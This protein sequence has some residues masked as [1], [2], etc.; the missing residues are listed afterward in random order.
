MKCKYCNSDLLEEN[1]VCPN[2]KKNNAE[3]IDDFADLKEKKSGFKYLLIFFIVLLLGIIGFGYYYVT[4]PDVVFTTLLNKVY[5][6]ALDKEKFEQ[7]KMTTNMN[8]KIDAKEEYKE[9]I[10]IINNINLKMNEHI[11]LTDST[12]KLEIGADYKE[13][14]LANLNAYYKDNIMYFELKDILDKVVKFDLNDIMDEVKLND[15]YVKDIEIIINN[16]YEALKVTLKKGTYLSSDVKVNGNNVSK[17]ELI[18]NNGNKGTLVNTFID[19]LLNSNDFINSI[20]R[21]TNKEK[22]EVIDFLNESK[23]LEDL[24][25]EIHISIY[26]KK[27]TNDFVKLEVAN[28]ENVT[29]SLTL[30]KENVYKIETKDLNGINNVSTITIDEKNDKVNIVSEVSFNDIKITI[31]IDASI[32]YNE[33]IEKPNVENAITIEEL[34]EDDTN[35]VMDNLM[36]NEGISEIMKVIEKVM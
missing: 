21:V 36:K 31:N 22:Q 20:S 27:L 25:E 3:V 2:C 34:S 13:K 15:S 12:F 23:K 30:E 17:N 7:L 24:E 6:E 19:Y 26:T 9:Y 32:I 29:W 10:D 5:K 28:K 14:L 35:K 4:Q 8:I 1:T 33:K 16:L 18:I 11:D